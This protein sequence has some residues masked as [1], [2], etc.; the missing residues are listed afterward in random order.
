MNSNDVAFRSGYLL[1]Q[2]DNAALHYF[3]KSGKVR[4]THKG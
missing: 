3:K 4:I 2:Q 1:A